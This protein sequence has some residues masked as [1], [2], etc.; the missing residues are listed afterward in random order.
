MSELC[1]NGIYL[2]NYAENIIKVF[3]KDALIIIGT[4]EDKNNFIRLIIDKDNIYENIVKFKSRREEKP[5][6]FI[7]KV[8]K[9]N[10]FRLNYRIKKNNTINKSIILF[11]YNIA[12]RKRPLVQFSLIKKFGDN[13]KYIIMNEESVKSLYNFNKRY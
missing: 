10:K 12:K 9:E 8:I 7:L 13:N 3:G 2:L 6:N 4:T 5:F 11:K 1:F